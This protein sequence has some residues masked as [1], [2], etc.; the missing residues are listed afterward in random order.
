M[1]LVRKEKQPVLIKKTK[2]PD[3][4]QRDSARK[5]PF[6]KEEDDREEG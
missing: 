6:Y 2:Q 3:R 4:N 1:R 5:K